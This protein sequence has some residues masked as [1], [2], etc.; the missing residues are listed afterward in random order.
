MSKV[1]DTLNMLEQ[2]SVEGQ[3][4]NPD[5]KKPVIKKNE[6]SPMDALALIGVQG[7]NSKFAIETNADIHYT[8][9]TGYGAEL[10]PTEVLTAQVYESIPKYDTFLSQIAATSHGN[11]MEKSQR[12][13]I[14]GRPGLMQRQAEKTSSPFAIK[15]PTHEL[16]TGKVLIEQ[17][18]LVSR[19]DISDWLVQF[20]SLG[21][22]G[23][24]NKIV[25]LASQ[26][27]MRTEE[28]AILNGDTTTAATGNV[29]SDDAAPAGTEYY[30]DYT[31]VRKLALDTSGASLNL[32]A[33]DVSDFRDLEKILALGRMWIP[34]ECFWAFNQQVEIELS[35][36]TQFTQSDL[37][38]SV[39]TPEGQ[40]PTRFDGARIYRHQDMPLTEADGKVSSATP[41]NNTLGTIALVYAPAIQWGRH[42]GIKMKM[43]DYGADGVQLEIWE[44]FGF[45]IVQQK[46]G[47]VGSSIA[48]GYNITV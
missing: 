24:V 23:F 3:R 46:A 6:L 27:V 35:D 39:G 13:R 48:Y 1:T 8:T 28:A 29:N 42:G 31:G 10:V 41:A 33:L 16:Q 4:N 21:A 25:E 5:T 47:Q 20:N 34:S 2:I 37:R 19:F 22:D 11:N 32:G 43:Y 40:M 38:G 7:T 14:I 44:Y 15:S 17:K 26:E 45:T 18:Q 12:V 9:R 30:L 36:L